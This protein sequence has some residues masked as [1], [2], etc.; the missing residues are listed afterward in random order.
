M[1][2]SRGRVTIRA[3]VNNVN[4]VQY[5]KF[6]KIL[7]KI[8]IGQV[9]KVNFSNLFGGNSAVLEEIANSLIQNQPEFLLQEIYPPI[10]EHLSQTFTAIANKIATSATFDE[11]FPL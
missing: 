9:R 1:D 11:V 7:I 3:R 8:Q 10:E 4:G 5:I 2:N 6:D